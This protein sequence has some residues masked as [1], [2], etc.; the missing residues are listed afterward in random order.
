[1]MK[2]IISVD[3]FCNIIRSAFYKIWCEAKMISDEVT[4]VCQQWQ[5][6]GL[7]SAN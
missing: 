1:M 3:F 4:P 7:L 5:I 2:L 6:N